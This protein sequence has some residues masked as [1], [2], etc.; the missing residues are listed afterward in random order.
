MF[1]DP[2]IRTG[3]LQGQFRDGEVPFQQSEPGEIKEQAVKSCE[4]VV[5]RAFEQDICQFQPAPQQGKPEFFPR[6]GPGNCLVHFGL[7]KIL[8]MICFQI[9]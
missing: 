9:K 7:D 4:F 2:D 8:C 1:V 5:F 3:T 6:N